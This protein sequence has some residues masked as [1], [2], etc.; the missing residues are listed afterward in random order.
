METYP[1]QAMDMLARVLDQPDRGH[2]CRVVDDSAYTGIPMPRVCV[3]N[4][5]VNSRTAKRGIAK[6]IA[7]L[8]WTDQPQMTGSVLSS[9]GIKS[10][11][12]IFDF[13]DNKP[14]PISKEGLFE[15]LPTRG[16]RLL[17]VMQSE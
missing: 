16:S 6:H 1:P 15:L 4:Y 5:P 3:I 8:N 7:L 2:A 9:L 10:N 17:T 12:N 11:A 13:W 14:Y